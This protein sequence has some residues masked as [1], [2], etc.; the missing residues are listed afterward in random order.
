MFTEKICLR[1]LKVLLFH[2]IRVFVKV[3]EVFAI[4]NADSVV[5]D[6]FPYEVREQGW[7]EFDIDIKVEFKNDAEHPVSFIHSLK[8]HPLN[9]EPSELDVVLRLVSI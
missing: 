6:H 9:G 1:L 7:G 5:I 3:R 4:W 8:L 2:F